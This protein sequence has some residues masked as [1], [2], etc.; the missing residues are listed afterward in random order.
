MSFGYCSLLMCFWGLRSRSP[1]AY[2][3]PQVKFTYRA[4]KTQSY[5]SIP[6]LLVKSS[7]FLAKLSGKQTCSLQNS[8]RA[9]PLC[10]T[11]T[12]LL[13]FL[14]SASYPISRSSL[15]RSWRG[16]HSSR[17]EGNFFLC[18]NLLIQLTPT[19]H[20]MVFDADTGSTAR[21]TMLA[22]LTSEV[23]RLVYCFSSLVSAAGSIWESEQLR[24]L[25]EGLDSPKGYH[26][27][28]KITYRGVWSSSSY[29]CCNT[30]LLSWRRKLGTTYG[31]NY[32]YPSVTNSF[33]SPIQF[34]CTA[35]QLSC[36]PLF[37]WGTP[38]QADA[39]YTLG[40]SFLQPHSP[41]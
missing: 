12:P 6:Y 2:R 37:S 3:K 9:R 13:A 27:A 11:Q 33:S 35:W 4:Q 29:L 14:I 15:Q 28:C 39:I 5:L 20:C 23:Y 22:S 7:L 17:T 10:T 38:P 41:Q 40:K 32:L 25:A 36:L 19:K 26:W 16:K 34:I 18:H 30:W 31:T 24:F 21:F 1:W 8:L